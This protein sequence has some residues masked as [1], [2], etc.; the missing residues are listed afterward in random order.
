MNLS[1][2]R[3]SFSS[4]RPQSIFTCSEEDGRSWNL[5]S[6]PCWEFLYR[7]L[8]CGQRRSYIP[9]D[10]V[11]CEGVGFWPRFTNWKICP[12]M[13]LFDW[14]SIESEFDMP[15]FSLES[16]KW[17]IFRRLSF[18]LWWMSAFTMHTDSNNGG[19]WWGWHR[20]VTTD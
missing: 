7:I 10:I 9:G 5:D 11:S 3:W 18:W 14:H 2:L 12:I 6:S 17:N 4:S 20:A 19:T 15:E 13:S 16:S 1:K 8:S